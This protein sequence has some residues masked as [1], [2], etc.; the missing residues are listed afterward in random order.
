MDTPTS[1]TCTGAIQTNMRGKSDVPGSEAQLKG[2][3]SAQLFIAQPS[4]TAH[5]PGEQ[6]HFFSKYAGL[7][8]EKVIASGYIYDKLCARL[9]YNTLNLLIAN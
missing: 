3:A 4:R 2:I 6:K 1:S 5:L 8:V 7:I 9:K